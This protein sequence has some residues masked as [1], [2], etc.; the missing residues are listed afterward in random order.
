MAIRYRLRFRGK[1]I[2]AFESIA[3]RAFVRLWI[4][5]GVLWLLSW[6]PLWGG[7]GRKDTLNPSSGS[8]EGFGGLQMLLGGVVFG[9][10]SFLCFGSGC[11]G[12]V[13]TSVDSVEGPK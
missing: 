13:V 10:L 5:K 8:A 2:G 1:F 4:R 7:H 12:I 3:F 9:F 11:Q 6:S